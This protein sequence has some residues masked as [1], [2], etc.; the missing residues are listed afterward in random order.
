VSVLQRPFA[1]RWLNVAVAWEI[2]LLALVL[3][4][5]VLQRPFA[6][7]AMSPADWALVV[8]VAATVLPVLDVAKAVLR[9][10]Q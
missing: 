2:T 6:T 4:L 7:F 5:P 9:R 10:G 3:Y 1:N 8:G